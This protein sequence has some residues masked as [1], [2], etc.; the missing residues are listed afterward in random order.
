[1]IN[2]DLDFDGIDRLL[3]EDDSEEEYKDESEA[4]YWKNIGICRRKNILIGISKA[5]KMFPV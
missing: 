2:G 1:M 4:A 3:T 5:M